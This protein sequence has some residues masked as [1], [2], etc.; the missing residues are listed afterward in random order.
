[1]TPTTK[2]LA[3][4]LRAIVPNMTDPDDRLRAIQALD[5]FE[6]AQ[7]ETKP[8][9]AVQVVVERERVWIKR[10]VQSFMLAYE[11]ET[12]AER[13]WYAGQLRAAL[14]GFT[15]D[16]K[17]APAA[18]AQVPANDMQPID[19]I[20]YWL[21]AYSDPASGEHFMGHGVVVKMLREYLQL[22]EAAAP[23]APAPWQPIETAPKD[24]TRILVSWPM[25][26]MDDS[27]LPSGQVTSRHTV[28]TAMNGGYWLEPDV[29]N[30]S[31]EWFGDEDCF[32]DSPDL[33]RPL[34]APPAIAASK[35]GGKP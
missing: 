12:D 22:R 6:Q 26:V 23:A 9:P 2:A 29:L 3:E 17:T 7:A 31:G 24:G 19:S 14:S 21:N 16:V 34:P 25:R 27:G 18:P 15:P 8:A 11:A 4:A 1:M 28:V 35:G 13:E 10:G 5:A 32:A 30:A 33:W 20:R